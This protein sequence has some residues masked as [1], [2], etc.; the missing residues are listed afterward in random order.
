MVRGFARGVLA[1]C[2]AGIALG[3]GGTAAASAASTPSSPN[4]SKPSQSPNSPRPRRAAAALSCAGLDQVFQSPQSGG[5]YPVTV[6]SN[7][8]D[9]IVG[10]GG[11][12]G[13]FAGP[14]NGIQ[15]RVSGPNQLSG[16]TSGYLFSDRTTY[17]PSQGGFGGT[18]QPF[19]ING[20]VP[21]SFTL[22]WTGSGQYTIGL[23]F[24]T[25]INRQFSFSGQCIGEA[26]VGYTRAI[27]NNEWTDDATYTVTIGTFAPDPII[28]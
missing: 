6:V 3:V 7:Q 1:V 16:S 23:N 17:T 26:L 20:P 18:Y 24:G 22:T 12:S 5:G 14:A 11:S 27:G 25:G 2:A 4:R 8:P 10:F 21:F 13:S 9:G 28:H 15:G 19:S